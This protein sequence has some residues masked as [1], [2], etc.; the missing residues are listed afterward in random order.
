MYI[1]GKWVNAVSGKTYTAV[2]P[3]TEE[4]VAEIPLGGQ[5]DVD[6]AV[7]AARK[8]FPVWA[9]MPPAERC[10]LLEKMAQLQREFVDELTK[11]EILDHG[12]PIRVAK[13]QSGFSS[14]T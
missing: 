14:T 7:A 8:A 5:A 1:G 4:V 13:M 9:G 3:A 11:W 12:T 6:L 2:N 10:R